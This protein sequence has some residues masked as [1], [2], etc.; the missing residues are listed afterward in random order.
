MATQTN[1]FT[2]ITNNLKAV[3]RGAMRSFETE[4]DNYPKTGTRPLKH[5][6][7]KDGDDR[8]KH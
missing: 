8:H 4:H 2:R 7:Y 3:L 5:D 1:V 6:I